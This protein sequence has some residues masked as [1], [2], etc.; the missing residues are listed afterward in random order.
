LT[1]VTRTA[2]RLTGGLRQSA[3]RAKLEGERRLLQRQ[4]RAALETL[5]SRVVELVRAEQLDTSTFGPEIATVEAKLMEIDAKTA[6]INALADEP[7][8]EP[9][10]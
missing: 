4:H 6:E 10:L 2:G 7:P 9:A 3:R 8:E 5:G 1:N